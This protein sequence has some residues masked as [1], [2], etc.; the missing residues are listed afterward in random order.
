MWLLLKNLSYFK[1]LIKLRTISRNSLHKCQKRRE[2]FNKKYLLLSIDKNFF[3]RALY[4]STAFTLQTYTTC[5]N[6]L[7]RE[8]VKEIIK[9]YSVIRYHEPK[10]LP[11]DWRNFIKASLPLLGF[12]AFTYLFPSCTP[13][14][15][16]AFLLLNLKESHVQGLFMKPC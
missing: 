4:Y 12:Q 5:S 11:F 1:Y 3:R 2:T 14:L 8:E 15:F 6:K 7:F 13:E 9:C 10:W 16:I